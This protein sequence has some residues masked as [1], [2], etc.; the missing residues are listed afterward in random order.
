[1]INNKKIKALLSLLEK[2]T[3]PPW[4]PNSHFDNWGN[5]FVPSFW[6][7]KMEKLSSDNSYKQA[8]IDSQAACAAFNMIFEIIDE[9]KRLQKENDRLKETINN[10]TNFE[11]D[12]Y[13][14][15]Q[16]LR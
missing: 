5:Y 9:L 6:S 14:H 7:K 4:E 13:I 3:S 16:E 8:K 10:V 11:F 1:M 15:Q 2:A 12:P